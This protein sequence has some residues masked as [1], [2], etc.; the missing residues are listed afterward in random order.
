MPGSQ[1]GGPAPAAWPALCR[2][3]LTGACQACATAAGPHQVLLRR[4][5]LHDIGDQH[6]GSVGRVGLCAPHGAILKHL[7]DLCVQA[8]SSGG[9][10]HWVTGELCSCMSAQL[11][12]KRAPA[13]AGTAPETKPGGWCHHQN[14]LAENQQSEPGGATIN[15]AA[16]EWARGVSRLLWARPA[17]VQACALDLRLHDAAWALTGMPQLQTRQSGAPRAP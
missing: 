9:H 6:H 16:L 15:Q 12:L 10:A 13:V 5:L 17:A 11:L 7:Q 1:P 8:G 14:W 3:A 2:R 4:R